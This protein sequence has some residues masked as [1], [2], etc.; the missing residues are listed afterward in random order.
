MVDAQ[1][2]FQY[3]RLYMTKLLLVLGEMRERSTIFINQFKFTEVN[4][5]DPWGVEC[6]GYLLEQFCEIMS[7][8]RYLKLNMA[9][10]N[11][12][13]LLKENVLHLKHY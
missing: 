10:K 12:K 9:I 11:S 6:M 2:R 7:F 8:V 3:L 1:G 4:K 13:D 5:N